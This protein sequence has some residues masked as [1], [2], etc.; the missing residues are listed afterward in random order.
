ME[1]E[2]NLDLQLNKNTEIPIRTRWWT[3]GGSK[4]KIFDEQSLHKTIDYVLNQQ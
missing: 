3:E 4:Q 1:D 2:G